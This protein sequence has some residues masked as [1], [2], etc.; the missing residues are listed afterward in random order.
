M[1]KTAS[2]TLTLALIGIAYT[3]SAWFLGKNVEARVDEQYSNLLASQ[4]YLRIVQR[5]YRRGIFQSEETVTL[6]LAKLPGAVETPPTPPGV[7]PVKAMELTFHT[8]IQHGP[9]PGLSGLGA[10]V[11]DTELVLS[12]EAK[13][14]A[15]RLL[16]DKAPYRQHSEIR[17]DGSGSASFSS[18]RF[19][20]TF[21]GQ[22]GLNQRIAWDGIEGRIDF[23]PGARTFTLQMQ[24]PKLLIT[25]GGDMEFVLTDFA[26]EGDQQQLF[27]DLP[28]M[29]TGS[30][31]FS[32]GEITA[33][34]GNADHPPV[35]IKQLVY[36][37]DLPVQGD[38]LDLV[39]RV[40][41]ESLTIGQDAIGPAHLDFSF[42]HLQARA[43]AELNQQLMSIYGDPTLQNSTPQELASRLGSAMEQHAATIL[44]S[45][46]QFNI[47]RV[48]LA[49]PDGEARLAARARLVGASLEELA[50]PMIL[51]ARLEATGD[52]ALSEQM[53]V[54]LLRNPPFA[55]RWDG[56]N[57]TPDEISARGQA[58][59]ER[60]QAQVAMLTEQ[61]YL[62]REKDLIETSM[63][64]KAGQ[65]T[66][67]GKPFNPTG[68]RGAETAQ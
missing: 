32:F 8:R 43:V 62:N 12:D 55:G 36:D 63:A 66:V 40:G 61:G 23:T 31:H 18:P 27:S 54:Q 58:A 60:F 25:D 53:V 56:T 1:K 47:D 51:L 67:N 39:A 30:S 13:T 3:A 29:Y 48:S 9:F 41:A 22:G 37:I 65:L 2:M 34:D 5:D 15:T 21:P 4:P 50:N 10:A 20:T 59:A 68:E 52:L 44:A 49:N 64:F 11:T 33:R 6:S 46:P 17:F 28:Y 45:D 24:A 7:E 26:F 14:Q 35:V 57:L 16:G 19:E 42:R 38:Y